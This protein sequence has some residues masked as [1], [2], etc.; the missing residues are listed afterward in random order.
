MRAMIISCFIFLSPISH[1]VKITN[2]TNKDLVLKIAPGEIEL[3]KGAELNMSD[4][5]AKQLGFT[6][7]N[8]VA[9]Y[10]E[11]H[12]LQGNNALFETINSDGKKELRIGFNIYIDSSSQVFYSGLNNYNTIDITYWDSSREDDAILI[13]V[14]KAHQIEC[15][16]YVNSK[17]NMQCNLF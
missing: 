13:S 17:L 10:Y 14:K 4:D 5:F 16:D 8:S 7:V 11:I 12:D 15:Q 3:A 2:Q 1:A 6:L 9:S